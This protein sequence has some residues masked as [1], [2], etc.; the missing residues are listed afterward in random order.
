MTPDARIARLLR[1]LL[2]LTLGAP[3][4]G[5]AQG[6]N[7]YEGDPAA[8]RAGRAL[9][10][11]RCAECHGADA[12]GLNGPDLTSLWAAATDERVF[13]TIRAGVPGSIMPSSQAPEQELWALVSYLKSVGTV[14][15]FES[16]AGDVER[17]RERFR[18]A[19][20]RCHRVAGEGGTAGPDLSR[21]ARVRTRDALALA[22]RNPSAQVAAGYRAVT[23]TT[24]DGQRVRGATKAEDA[25]SIQIVDTQGRMQ[26]YLKSD[27]RELA[28]EE[29]SLMPAFGTD[30]LDDA[31]LDDLLGYLSTLR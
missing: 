12:R 2:L 19:C 20:S 3:S 13:R 4:P 17:G 6:G 25:F 24:R 22:I 8:I 31:A 9:F 30:R 7:P 21:I 27:L 28:R 15:A 23:L 18:D 29:R 26:G 5:I 14:T 1:L 11:N 16:T 10:T